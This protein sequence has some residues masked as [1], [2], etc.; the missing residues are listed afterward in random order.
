MKTPG[1]SYSVAPRTRNSIANKVL[2]QPAPP[3]TRVGR[4]AGNPPPVISSSPRIPLRALRKA[5]K[6]A[7]FCVFMCRYLKSEQVT[8]GCRDLANFTAGL[9]WRGFLGQQE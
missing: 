7:N 1:S 3:Q 9:D 5:F 6:V 4:S 2:P 8:E